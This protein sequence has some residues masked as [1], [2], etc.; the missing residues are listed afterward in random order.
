MTD[1]RAL[2]LQKALAL[3]GQA[4]YSKNKLREKLK[5]VFPLEII[6]ETINKLEESEL[7]SEERELGIWLRYYE[8]GKKSKREI[9]LALLNR[10]FTRNLIRDHLTETND[11]R[12]EE[13]LKNLIAQMLKRPGISHDKVFQ[14]LLRRGFSASAIKKILDNPDIYLEDEI[15]DSF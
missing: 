11:N 3:L 6:E 4:S 14:R 8:S 9:E 10:G 7:Y 12:E 15:Y 13:V 2:C 1:Q 5:P